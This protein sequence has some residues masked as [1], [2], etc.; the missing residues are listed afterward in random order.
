MI[1]TR[2]I[3]L[4]TLMEIL[5][6]KKY[7]HLV[8]G[9]VLS[10]YDY[11]E[12]I[13]RAFIKRV[14]MGT[15][16]QLIKIDYIINQYSKT[17]TNKMKPFIRTL[18]RMSVYQIVFM[19]TI[20]DS[21][22]CNEAVKLAVKRSFSSL[23][24]FVNGVLRTISREK[25]SISYPSESENPVQYLS[26]QYSMPEWIVM[27]WLLDFS[28]EK[29]KEILEALL[30][31]RP[32]AVRLDENLNKDEIV[33]LLDEIKAANIS[34]E[35]STALT[36]AYLLG[37]IE[38]VHK[39][40]G[41]L[42]GKLMVQD[43]GSM[44]ITEMA[45]IK[46][47]DRVLDVCAAPG[48]KTLH[49]AAKLAGSGSVE[50]RDISLYKINLIQENIARSPYQNISTKIWDACVNDENEI[51][52]A[53][54]VI[55]DLP[56]SG[57]GV[58]G[59]KADIKYRVQPDDLKEIAALQRKILDTVYA[60]VKVGGT[61]LY[62]TCTINRDENQNN[63]DYIL[64]HLPFELIDEKLLLPGSGEWDGFYMAAFRRIDKG[65]FIENE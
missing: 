53:D 23:R 24:G 30:K 60:Y 48:G 32:V 27:M 51:E 11:L 39:V 18:L 7:S 64:N 37:T 41:F 33:A 17:K 6:Q 40:P 19:Q 2:E 61:L 36:Y 5:E 45:D 21:A 52:K 47:N 4:E 35:Q 16:E 29:T 12:R 26:V 59:R 54:V 14:C 38:N 50:A 3:I 57:L 43:I 20:P 13:D 22:A 58:I 8:I 65:K 49:A 63:R 15:I 1:N 34:I 44:L 25:D 62:S 56:C 9:Q 10:K 31:E 55:A 28:F 42:E 46:K